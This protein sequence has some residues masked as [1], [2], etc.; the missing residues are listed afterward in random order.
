MVPMQPRG[1][2]GLTDLLDVEN[3]RLCRKW[4]Y[5]ENNPS[6][7]SLRRLS[8]EA[9]DEKRKNGLRFWYDEIVNR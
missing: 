3:P 9:M 7:A 2:G 4:T 6:V 8:G 1:G 5:K